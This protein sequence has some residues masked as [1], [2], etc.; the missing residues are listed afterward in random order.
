M[1]ATGRG[2]RRPRGRR[3]PGRRRRSGDGVRPRPVGGV[4]HATCWASRGRQ[5]KR[6]ARATSGSRACS[7][8]RLRVARLRLGDET[9]ELTQYL[10]P[11]GRPV[12]VDSRSN[13]RWFQHIAIVVADMDRAY[14]RL[15]AAP[16][17]AR[18]VRAA[19]AAR[20]EPE[21]RRHRR[22]LLPGPRRPSLEV[23][24]FPPG[25][26]DPRWQA[27]GGRALPRHRPHRDRGRRHR[28]EPRASTGTR[29]AC[30]SRARARTTGPSRST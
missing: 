21:R 9:L 5:R 13:D 27:A 2:R 25:K 20:L 10:A 22:L 28:G 7:G 23:I 16:R 15:R 19:A 6:P 1:R 29:W 8:S 18:L 24:Y 4:L 14:A 17:R 30:R 12:P 11:R 26:G 3:W